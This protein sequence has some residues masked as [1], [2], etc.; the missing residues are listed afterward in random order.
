M[1][2]LRFAAAS[3]AASHAILAAPPVVAQPAAAPWP[4]K[5]IRLVVGFPPGGPTDV[6][7][8]T[9]G[10]RLGEVLGQTIVVDNRPGA[11]GNLGAELVAKSPPDGYTML[12]GTVA[13]TIAP[14]IY[15]DLRYHVQRDLAP[16]SLVAATPFVVAVNPALPV[17][18]IKE[19][20]AL[21]KAQPGKHTC[22]SAGNGSPIHLACE[23]FKSMA[24]VQMTHVPYSGSAPAL[25]AV[26]GGHVSVMFE[27]INTAMPMIRGAKVKGLA[28]AAKQRFAG[29][30]EMPTVDESGV[31]GYEANTW[32]GLFVPIQ[33]P[34]PV[35]QRIHDA[36]VAA[37]K[38]P[39][40]G[41]RLAQSGADPVG[42]SPEQ[43]AAII[44]ADLAKWAKAVKESG[45]KID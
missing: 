32:S 22:S 21:L 17:N 45:A 4:T 9:I 41:Q 6:V 20:I 31:P 38:T 2:Q 16:V 26:A 23:I 36:T 10:Q 3:L 1:F 44:R 39:E 11:A 14:A 7:A 5:P 30:P 42:N 24:G 12:L 40:V 29:A 43:F 19:F 35:V 25:A 33:T 37:L 18:N 34:K 27:T 13:T 28:V 15:K 8:R